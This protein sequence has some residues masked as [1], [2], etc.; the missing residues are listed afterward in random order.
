MANVAIVILSRKKN[1][2]N[3]VINTIRRMAVTRCQHQPEILLTRGG[4][5]AT[6]LKATL[7][8]DT[9]KTKNLDQDEQ[10]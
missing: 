2:L 5:T 1:A 7:I 8:Q 6:Q 3:A 9:I 4:A 10:Q